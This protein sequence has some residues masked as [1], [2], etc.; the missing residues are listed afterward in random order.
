MSDVLDYYVFPTSPFV[1][2]GH[3]A[4]CDLVRERGVPVALKPIDL[5]RVFP[6]SGGLPL[7]QRAPQRQAYRLAELQRW[8]RYRGLPL[9]PHPKHFPVAA[10]A[11][12]R[13]VADPAIL[14][15]LAASLGLDAARLAERANAPDTR[16]HY[17][18]LTQEAIDRGVF[19]VPTYVL[20]G[21]MFWGQDRLDFLA[22]A[23]AQ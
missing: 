9:N 19:G 6:V 23:L 20:N 1:Y 5:G 2:L 15:G 11:E 7:K 8:A 17:D 13:D 22:R 21:E 4:F 14:H 10:W 12:D 16:V 3:Q 18:S